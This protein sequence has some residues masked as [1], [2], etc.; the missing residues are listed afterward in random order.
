MQA[1]VGVDL[2][3]YGKP[4]GVASLG[5]DG[6][7]LRLKAIARLRGFDEITE[8]I[9]LQ[10]GSR[11]AVIAVDAPLIITIASGN[12]PAEREL[13][14]NFRCYDAGYPA[15]LGRPFA[16]H[17]L[18]FSAALRSVGFDHGPDITARQKGRYQIEV[19]PHSAI[20]NLFDLSLI[21][22]YKHGLR[23][24]RAAELERLRGLMLSRLP[25]LDPPLL[26]PDLPDIPEFG[27][28]KP[29][30]DQ[31]DAIVCGYCAAFWWMWGRS[32]N[33]VFGN[34][35][36]GYI[37]VPHRQSFVQEPRLPKLCDAACS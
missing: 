26:L 8:W 9:Q 18:G 7:H 11:D 4:S 1:F 17:V 19:Y 21:V 14:K 16:K 15:N 33:S 22:K 24:K 29:V 6:D 27:A 34:A 36:E 10:A 32:R 28:L 35:G 13:N 2:G 3:W 12:R 25:V 30:E 5:W 37:V 31:L 20:V 23:S